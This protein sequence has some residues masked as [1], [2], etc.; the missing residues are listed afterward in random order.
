MQSAHKN[1]VPFRATRRTAARRRTLAAMVSAAD[2]MLP[3]IDVEAE[4]R[5]NAAWD[6][7]LRVAIQAWSWRDPESLEVLEEALAGVSGEVERD[8][9]P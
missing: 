7:M 5:R 6:E 9:Q 4:E 3:A 1:V 8:W 2:P